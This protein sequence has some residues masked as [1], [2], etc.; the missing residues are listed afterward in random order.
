MGS[1]WDFGLK[2]DEPEAGKAS[3]PRKVNFRL[4][5]WACVISALALAVVFVAIFFA[6]GVSD[7]SQLAL[8]L[9]ALLGP[10]FLGIIGLMLLKMAKP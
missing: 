6:S 9:A 8:V 10:L 4:Y 3:P 2:K 7:T 1:I 5:G